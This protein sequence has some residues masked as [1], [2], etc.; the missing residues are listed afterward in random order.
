MSNRIEYLYLISEFT[1]DS[2]KVRYTGSVSP[3]VD[4]IHRHKLAGYV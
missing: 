2:D 3:S 4:G 1:G